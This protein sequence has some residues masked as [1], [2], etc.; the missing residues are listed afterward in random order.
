MMYSVGLRSTTGRRIIHSI[1]NNANWSSIIIVVS[2][3]SSSGPLWVLAVVFLPP[4]RHAA[5]R[6]RPLSP[7]PPTLSF[8]VLLD[9][10]SRRLI[11]ASPTNFRY[12][13]RRRQTGVAFRHRAGRSVARRT[14]RRTD[15]QSAPVERRRAEKHFRWIVTADTMLLERTDRR[16]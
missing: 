16:G 14:G 8:Q 3:S 10:I 12:F 9:S 1:T 6:P 5:I 4:S 15:G 7:P 11:V 2:S 13:Q